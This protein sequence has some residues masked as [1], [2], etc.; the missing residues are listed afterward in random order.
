[1]N[2]YTSC[3]REQVRLL[4][5]S[6]IGH[7]RVRGTQ[8]KQGGLRMRGAPRG[9]WLLARGA[10]PSCANGWYW[11][12]YAGSQPCMRTTATQRTCNSLG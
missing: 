3:S 12:A 10:W 1:M 2:K 5:I 9:V 6:H 11:N 4:V 8:K 7:C